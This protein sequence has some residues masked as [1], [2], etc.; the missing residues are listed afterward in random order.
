MFDAFV[1][2]DYLGYDWED[3]EEACKWLLDYY[4]DYPEAWNEV[5]IVERDK[6]GNHLRVIGLDK[7]G[8]LEEF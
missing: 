4:D 2:G 7:H 5:H 1:A 6:E 8:L 3:E